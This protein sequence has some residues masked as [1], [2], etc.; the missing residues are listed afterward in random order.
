MA[1]GGT[2]LMAARQR[3]AECFTSPFGM[4]YRASGRHK[5]RPLQWGLHYYKENL[6]AIFKILS[7]SQIRRRSS[8]SR[9]DWQLLLIC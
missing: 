4:P 8:N 9:V 5:G 3:N 2:A 7:C 6:F 1:L